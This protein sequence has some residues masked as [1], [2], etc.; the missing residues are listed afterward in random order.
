M[1]EGAAAE[2]M[3]VVV[4]G[5][6]SVLL[7]KAGAPLGRLSVG[8]FFGEMAALIPPSMAELR[9]RTR[10]A[11]ATAETQLGMITHDELMEIRRSSME[12]NEKVVEYTNHILEHAK[13]PDR[14]QDEALSVLDAHPELKAL[15][16]I[17]ERKMEAMVAQAIAAIAK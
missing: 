16:R 12:V 4:E 13:G 2:E 11:S 10:S 17:L 5:S 8:D 14:Q 15:E 6:S 1:T 9:R 7:E 3:F